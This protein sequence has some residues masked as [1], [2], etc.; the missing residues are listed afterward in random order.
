MN[1]QWTCSHCK[2]VINVPENLLGKSAP[3]PNPQCGEMIDFPTTLTGPAE[4]QGRWTPRRIGDLVLAGSLAVVFH[5]ALLILAAYIVSQSKAGDGGEYDVAIAELPK[6]E[7]LTKGEEGGLDTSAETVNRSSTSDAMETEVITAPTGPAS[8]VDADGLPGELNIAP[9]GGGGGNANFSGGLTGG[10][11][12]GG[13]GFGGKASFMGAEATGK[14]F[15]IIADHSG[16]MTGPP[17]ERVKK[18]M[19]RTLNELQPGSEFYIIFFDHAATP[20]P[21]NKWYKARADIAKATPWI[22]SMPI[23]G[24]TDPTMAFQHAFMMKPLPD[25]VFFMTDGEIPDHSAQVADQVN[26]KRAGK[27]IPIHTILFLNI[28]PLAEQRMKT[29]ATQSGGTYRPVRGF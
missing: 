27:K 4:L 8:G 22:Q 12:G 18:E 15:L 13:G 29:I 11:G 14:R 21:G 6:G 2:K 7:E 26:P 1:L 17:L 16:S 19:I 28:T 5:V 9:S 23:G 24:G 10:A 20:M 25:A 3:C